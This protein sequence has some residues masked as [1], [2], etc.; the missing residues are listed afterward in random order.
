MEQDERLWRSDEGER[1]KWHKEMC[2]EQSDGT[3]H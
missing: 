3:L 2:H 1:W